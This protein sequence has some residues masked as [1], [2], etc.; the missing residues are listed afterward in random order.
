MTSYQW[1]ASGGDSAKRQEAHDA[2]MGV[3]Y[4]TSAFGHP[5]GRFDYKAETLL[6]E[7]EVPTATLEMY[8]RNINQPGYVQNFGCCVLVD[9]SSNRVLACSD[10]TEALLGRTAETVLDQKVFGL[11][12]E[13]QDLHMFVAGGRDEPNMIAASPVSFL[14][15]RDKVCIVAHTIEKKFILMDI[16]PFRS[17][18]GIADGMDARAGVIDEAVRGIRSAVS[19]EELFQGVVDNIRKLTGYDRCILYMFHEDAHGHVI[20]ESLS[21]GT[22]SYLHI[23]FPASD[24]PQRTR[25]LLVLNKIRLIV[26]SSQKQSDMMVSK[27]L[28]GPPEAVPLTLSTLRGIHPCHLEYLTNWGVLGTLTISIIVHGKLWGII[29]CHMIQTPRFLS[30][31]ARKNCVSVVEAMNERLTQL[32]DT[33]L[34]IMQEKQSHNIDT[35]VSNV[36]NGNFDLGRMVDTCTDALMSLIS[37]VVGCAVVS[38]GKVYST[39]LVPS[40][41]Q[42]LRIAEWRTSGQ[43]RCEPVVHCMKDEISEIVVDGKRLCGI[44]SIILRSEAVIA[45]FRIERQTEKKWAGQPKTSFKAEEGKSTLAPRLSFGAF[46]ES[47][48]WHSEAW[49]AANLEVAVLFEERLNNAW[50]DF[51]PE[52]VFLVDFGGKIVGWNKAMVKAT[53][54]DCESALQQPLLSLCSLSDSLA[55]PEAVLLATRVGKFGL[56]ITMLS[57]STDNGTVLLSGSLHRLYNTMGSLVIMF[58]GSV[59]EDVNGNS[60]QAPDTITLSRNSA[61]GDR[62]RHKTIEYPRMKSI[63]LPDELSILQQV[64][65]P[66]WLMQANPGMSR[67]VWGNQAAC[68]LFG[69]TLQEFVCLDLTSERSLSE[70]VD[71]RVWHQKVQVNRQVVSVRKTLFMGV[72]PITLDMEIRPIDVVFA[73]QAPEPHVIVF[74]SPVSIFDM[75]QVEAMRS[76]EM[77]QQCR[78]NMMLFKRSGQLL[79][80]NVPARYAYLID[81]LSQSSPGTV[82]IRTVY[83]GCMWNKEDQVDEC[84]HEILETTARGKMHEIEVLKPNSMSTG[85]KVE[86]IHIIRAFPARDPYTGEDSVLV[87]EIDI[88]EVT[89]V[90]QELTAQKQGRFV[91][92]VSHE[93]RTPLHGIM[94]LS[95][96]LMLEPQCSEEAKRKLRTII[97]CSNR[98]SSLINDILDA[99]SMKESRF[100]LSYQ[101]VCLRDVCSDVCETLSPMVSSSLELINDVPSDLPMIRGDASRLSQVV[102]NLVGNSLKF[103]RTGKIRLWAENGTGHIA[104]FVQ[105]TGSGIPENVIDNIFDPFV[106]G[107]MSATRTYGGTGLGLSIVKSLVESHGGVIRVTS[108]QDPVDHG[109]KFTI[110]LPT[111]RSEAVVDASAHL[112]DTRAQVKPSMQPPLSPSPGPKQPNMSPAALAKQFSSHAPHISRSSVLVMQVVQLASNAPDEAIVSYTQALVQFHGALTA[113][114]ASNSTMLSASAGLELVAITSMG[115]SEDAELLS[116][117]RLASDILFAA[118]AAQVTCKGSDGRKVTVPLFLRIAVGCGSVY[119]GYTA[120]RSKGVVA[121]GDTVRSVSGLVSTQPPGRLHIQKQASMLLESLGANANTQCL[122]TIGGGDGEL[123][124]F[125]SWDSAAKTRN[126]LAGFVTELGVSDPAEIPRVLEKHASLCGQ[127]QMLQAR[128]QSPGGRPGASAMMLSSMPVGMKVRVLNRKYEVVTV[129]DN[130]INQM[131]LESILSGDEYKLTTC[132]SGYECLD[133][134]QERGDNGEQLPDL[135][136]LDVMMPLMS[137]VDL[138]ERLRKKYDLTELPIVMLSAQ[139]THESIMQCFKAGANDFINKP[140]DGEELRARIAMHIRVRVLWGARAVM[141]P[142]GSSSAKGESLSLDNG[143]VAEEL[144]KQGAVDGAILIATI[145]G[146]DVTYT[147]SMHD[148]STRLSCIAGEV[149]RLCTQ[150]S[151]ITVASTAESYTLVCEVLP[152][153]LSPLDRLVAVATEIRKSV[154]EV[155]DR[156]GSISV[157][158]SIEGGELWSF[159]CPGSR[160]TFCGSPV[161]IARKLDST[162]AASKNLVVGPVAHAKLS[163]RYD[164]MNVRPNAWFVANADFA[165]ESA[166]HFAKAS[167]GS[168]ASR[169]PTGFVSG[170]SKASTGLMARTLEKAELSELIPVFEAE[171]LTPDLVEDLSDEALKELGC[172]SMGSRLRLRKFAKQN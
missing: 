17:T 66:V 94:G 166:V 53:N 152:G 63:V 165:W 149:E 33:D 116:L 54:E 44:L 4:Q 64:P 2:A 145:I 67:F 125:L 115:L 69:K 143:P 146:Q 48:V 140:F 158:L 30:Y 132:M 43:G 55:V 46:I 47:T 85:E 106:Q 104:L 134:I 81:D 21:E 107:D 73:G 163:A 111:L 12:N 84:I 151:A 57:G 39:G 155:D 23:H 96:S 65:V 172:K 14:G 27:A 117:L 160:R 9:M 72:Q 71:M 112:D 25:S 113:A 13:T 164:L 62:V 171:E 50:M 26:D 16:E 119:E 38:E 110:W 58:M 100:I 88:S 6:K 86:E 41:E 68:A 118:Q 40:D 129:D 154:E 123:P 126:E 156:K 78:T 79:H 56:D 98:L 130:P 3:K 18:A 45:W 169:S 83:E 162:I 42:M 157:R 74:G 147:G 31:Q 144:P 32:I 135:V 136:L 51:L 120:D 8:S 10:N 170:S 70:E 35:L 15:A 138:C 11:F 61:A 137:G 87:Q 97:S 114:L 167:G 75:A 34:E 159:S 52:C 101:S 80:A 36:S 92:S 161:T 95:Q 82:T 122:P 93:L 131:V 19:R 127:I 108:T 148:L 103:T 76:L 24:T 29:A 89:V 49:G 128:R 91:A 90:K 141:M 105:D 5:P 99:A 139:V 28:N 133:L 7:R 102:T 150:Y 121:F 60:E 109:T 59:S 1:K 168:H 77:M 153:D 20:S 22:D 142:M 37:G 124:S